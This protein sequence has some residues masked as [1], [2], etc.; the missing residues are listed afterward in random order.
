MKRYLLQLSR[1]SSYLLATAILSHC[2]STTKNQQSSN[3]SAYSYLQQANNSTGKQ[4]DY[5]RLKASSAFLATERSAPAAKK[6][7]DQL[8]SQAASEFPS[9]YNL[10][11]AQLQWQNQHAKRTLFF[12]QNTDFNQLS[13][14]EQRL[15][16]R[17]QSQAA[18]Q[19]GAYPLSLTAAAQWA[20]QAKNTSAKEPEWITQTWKKLQNLPSNQLQEL[21]TNTNQNVQAWGSLGLLAKQPLAYNQLYSRLKQWKKT[22]KDSS[23]AA[24]LDI[25]NEQTTENKPEHIALLLP[26]SGRYNKSAQAIQNGFFAAYYAAKN[27]GY[28]PSIRVYDTEQNS[29]ENTYNQAVQ[30]GAQL[31]VGP[32]LKQN[33]AAL[34][35]IS[36]PTIALNQNTTDNA[37]KNLIYFAL[38]PQDEAQQAAIHAFA[39]GSRQALIFAPDNRW[40]KQVAQQFTQKW[41]KL[42]GK[43]THV[44]Y[45]QKNAQALHQAVKNSLLV[46]QSIA[47]MR[48]L[49]TTIRKNVRFNPRTRKDADMVFLIGSTYAA[50]QIRPFLRY[51]FAGSWPVYALSNINNSSSTTAQHDL[52]GI[53]FCDV[54][55]LV[56]PQLLPNSLQTMQQNSNDIWQQQSKSE[57]RLYAMG[58][59]AFRIINN[60]NRLHALPQLGLAGATGTLF[61]DKNGNIH[62]QLPW[63]RIQYGKMVAMR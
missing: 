47:R 38:S 54:P 57:K 52:N 61:L 20:T 56:Q 51:Y 35:H 63:A 58:V 46:D 30:Q 23:V 55:W 49:R 36:V 9:L 28:S 6:T 25:N 7:M 48:Q 45:Y 29:L 1:I 11:Q 39:A 4:Q 19:A 14:D 53:K 16:L 18:W 60:W 59:D 32:L 13:A 40:G 34:K 31:V 42:G 2:A 8:S 44:S 15:A 50:N 24:L 21:A 26:L 41:Q 37:R 43:V 5:Y 12:L 22:Y 33:V 62:R 3:I 10:V 17:T 27:Q